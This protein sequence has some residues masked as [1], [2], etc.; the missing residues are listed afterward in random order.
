MAKP[1]HDSNLDILRSAAVLAV[2]LSHAL[3]VTAGCAF[4][5]H[6][7]YGVETFSLGR[8]GVLL[9]FVHT[10]LVLMQ[11]LERAATN[12]ADWP[13]VKYF[14]V[15][16]AFRIYPLS[17]CLIL[18]SIAFSV[19]ANAL[20]VPY[21][22]HGVKWALANL[23]L[24][25]NITGAVVISSPLW[26]LPY[27]V[28]MYLVLPIL[29]PLVRAPRGGAR[30]ILIYIVAAPLSLFNPLFLYAPCF[31]AGVI[32]YKLLG[33]V[34]PR[35]PAWLWLPAVVGAVAFYLSRPYS[36]SSW[37][38]DVSICLIVGASIPLFKRNRGPIAAAASQIAKYSYGIYLC[39]TPVLWLVYRKLT[40][41]GWQRP[42]WTVIATGVVSVACY[43]AIEAP[44]IRIGTRLA[45]GMSV[46]PR[47]PAPVCPQWPSAETRPA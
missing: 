15:R 34:R 10:S 37:L 21:G 32:A 8:I 38:K 25:Q 16:R 39:H 29:F 31:L 18:L 14:Y 36:E 19:P 13:L 26:S 23:L 40:I 24:I 30:L 12:L 4:G 17:V 22:W 2:F 27:E 43:H 11:S 7:A 41:P 9:F 5:E 46:K 6:L 33:T 45:I 1:G 44:L 42:I 47:A 35:L 28:Q 20:G 3:E